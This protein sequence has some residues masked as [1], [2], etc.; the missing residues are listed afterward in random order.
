MD[1][2]RYEKEKMQDE[3]YYPENSLEKMLSKVI[4]EEEKNGQAE[5]HIRKSLKRLNIRLDVDY[6]EDPM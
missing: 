1:K 3:T 5:V 4:L 2:G 6:E